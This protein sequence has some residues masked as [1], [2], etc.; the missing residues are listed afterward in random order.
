M[1]HVL[2]TGIP[3]RIALRRWEEDPLDAMRGIIHASLI[4]LMFFWLP[5]AIA[6]RW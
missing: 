5:L 4:S 6:W 1:E 3:A 2:I